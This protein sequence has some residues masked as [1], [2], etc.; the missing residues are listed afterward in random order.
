[1]GGGADLADTGKPIE[2]MFP[3][4]QDKTYMQMSNYK[5]IK[6]YSNGM[7]HCTHREGKMHILTFFFSNHSIWRTKTTIN[8]LYIYIYIDL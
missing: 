4:Q 7:L 1:V 2:P 6:H 5:K 3:T 8:L